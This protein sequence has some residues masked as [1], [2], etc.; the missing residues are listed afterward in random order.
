MGDAR[1]RFLRNLDEYRDYTTWGNFTENFTKKLSFA[2]KNLPVDSQPQW[3]ALDEIETKYLTELIGSLSES[4]ILE[5]EK[6]MK[7]FIRKSFLRCCE[8]HRSGKRVLTVQEYEALKD[9]AKS[10]LSPKEIEEIF[11]VDGFIE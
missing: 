5:W 6:E 10:H 1:E 3:K 11:H 7:Y 9:S 2:D 8:L 4:E